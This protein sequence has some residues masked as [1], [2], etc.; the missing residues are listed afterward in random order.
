MELRGVIRAAAARS[1]TFRAMVDAIERSDA[2]V[3][4]EPQRPE[5]ELMG[6]IGL[7]FTM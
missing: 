7:S 5:W 3:Y 4:V 2:I 6:A 1:P